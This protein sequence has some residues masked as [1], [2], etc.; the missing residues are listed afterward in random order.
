[1]DVKVISTTSFYPKNDETENNLLII[2]TLKFFQ[3]NNQNQ[4][5]L[6]YLMTNKRTIV[7]SWWKNILFYISSENSSVSFL[8]LVNQLIHS[9]AEFL[10]GENFDRVMLSTNL[11][12]KN[13]KI[14]GN[15]VDMLLEVI[16][17]DSKA[18]LG[19]VHHHPF[20]SEQS[21][22]LSYLIPIHQIPNDLGFVECVVFKD[23]GVFARILQTDDKIQPQICSTG[24]LLIYLY[25]KVEYPK[26][27]EINDSIENF[28]DPNYI[29]NSAMNSVKFNYGYLPL[30]G[31]LEKCS[32][33]SVRLGPK[34]PYV[35]VL[36]SLNK[37]KSK[38]LLI[39]GLLG[40][41]SSATLDIVNFQYTPQPF[42]F[43]EFIF[44]LLIEN[45]T[46][47]VNWDFSALSN[48]NCNELVKKP[49]REMRDYVLNAFFDGKTIFI[50]KKSNLLF[51]YAIFFLNQKGKLKIIKYN[52]I[53]AQN[54]DTNITY[55]KIVNT[56]PKGKWKYQFFEAYG[57]FQE[58]VSPQDAFYECLQ[59]CLRCLKL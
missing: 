10:F 4:E 17:N 43:K 57:I 8:K 13:M 55:S 22:H 59:Q 24:I 36:I 38:N 12:E 52:D 20:F 3:E 16:K 5:K 47:G 18:S 35:A 34:S 51:I 56:I 27:E 31:K 32:I 48:Y 11:S 19:I 9:I 41:I 54:Y 26:L 50:W 23:D 1:M 25:M 14:F 45:R 21:N 46:N 49:F 58:S 33:S 37:D 42:E 53:H 30:Y 7:F 44:Y 15:Y 29:T 2:N 40:L 6:N 39:K 28:F